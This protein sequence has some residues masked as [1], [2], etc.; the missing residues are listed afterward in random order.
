MINYD[1]LIN[2]IKIVCEK[3]HVALEDFSVQYDKLDIGKRPPGAAGCASVKCN[4]HNH[5]TI[6]LKE[7]F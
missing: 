1:A 2:D 4:G 6:E 5:I 7:V 3:Y